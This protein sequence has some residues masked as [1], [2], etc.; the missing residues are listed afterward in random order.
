MSH[1]STKCLKNLLNVVLIPG[2]ETGAASRV[3]VLTDKDASWNLV[4]EVFS[5]VKT[6]PP[7]SGT[8]EI[9]LAGTPVTQ[10]MNVTLSANNSKTRFDIKIPSVSMTYTIM[11]LDV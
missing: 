11:T 5:E 10:R 2:F 4:V 3:F 1:T 6:G 8:M 9:K 7:V